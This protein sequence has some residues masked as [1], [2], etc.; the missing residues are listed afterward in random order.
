MKGFLSSITRISLSG[1]GSAL[2]ITSAAVIATVG[3]GMMTL[4]TFKYAQVT[5]EMRQFQCHVLKI[6]HPDCTDYQQQYDDLEAQREALAKELAALKAKV[7]HLH[8]LEGVD[9]VTLFS[10]HTLPGKKKLQVVVGTI[11]HTLLDVEDGYV[12]EHFCY[13]RLS[14][15]NNINRHLNIRS[16]GQ[17]HTLSSRIMRDADVNHFTLAFAHSHCKPYIIGGGK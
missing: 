14:D 6:A 4:Y 11:Y 13:I 17:D 15:E 5:P 9:S 3:L 10:R 1:L 8:A 2:L 16:G 12:P 7:S